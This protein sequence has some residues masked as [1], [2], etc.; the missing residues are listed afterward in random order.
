M[1]TPTPLEDAQAALDLL[2]QTQ[3]KIA[4]IIAQLTPAPP[5]P[6]PPAIDPRL[7][8][9]Q[10]QIG[11]AKVGVYT[12]VYTANYS[13]AQFEGIAVDLKNK[14]A[15]F[16]LVKMGEGGQVWHGGGFAGI[17]AQFVKHGLGC[18]AYW[19]CLPGG[20]QA[21]IDHCATLAQQVGMI[22]LDVEDEYKGQGAALQALLDGVCNAAPDAVVIVTGYGDPIFAFGNTFPHAVI[23]N[24]KITA[25]QPQAYFGV[26]SRYLRDGVHA[27]LQ[28]CDDECGLAYG[29]SIVLQP[30]INVQGV[31]SLLD[32]QEAG[33]FWRPFQASVV[34]WEYQQV[35]AD[36]IAAVK[37][38]L[39]A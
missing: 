25:Y 9:L 19:Y 22:T 2:Q 17:R 7:A 30:A 31:R 5:P 6:P 12:G 14:G 38:G 39:Q 11:A 33:H 37:R 35:T 8:K 3:G 28:W 1:S 13:W 4:D 27:A 20:G 21:Q 10:A 29:Q 15:D 24:S 26:W 36:I 18:A 32:F 34:I 16:A 23:R